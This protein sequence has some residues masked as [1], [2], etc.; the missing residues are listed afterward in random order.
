MTIRA[1]RI[2]KFANIYWTDKTNTL[3]QLKLTPL[4]NAVAAKYNSQLLWAR[5]TIFWFV[6]SC[7]SLKSFIFDFF[8]FFSS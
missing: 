3:Q 1:A 2:H 4:M 5:K 7:K 8:F 6:D